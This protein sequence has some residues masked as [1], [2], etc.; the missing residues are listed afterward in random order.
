[1]KLRSA[2]GGLSAVVVAV[3][4]VLVGGGGAGAAPTST[5]FEFVGWGGGSLVRAADNTITSDL[6][7]ASSINNQGLVSDT[8]DV[9]HVTVKDL[10]NTGEV[11]T[12]A[13]SSA[14]TGGYQV[15]SEARTAGI[16][17]LGGLITADAIDT[18]SI[19]RVVDGVASTSVSTTFVNLKVGS[20]HV[21]VNVKPNTIIRIPNVATVALNYQ[22][23]FTQNTDSA[24]VIGIGAYVSLLKPRGENAIGAELAISPT[25]SQLEPVVVP[26]SGHFLYAKAYGTKVTAKVGDLAGIQSDETAPITMAAAGTPNGEVDTSEIAGV[27]LNPLATVG[28]VVDSVQGTNTSAAY[29]GQ[30][31]SRIGAI[32]LLNGLIRADAV[33]SFARVQG[34]ATP[35]LPHVT[36]GST[37]VNLIING[38]PITLGT[39][40]NKVINILNVAKIT[41]NQQIRPNSHSLI[42]RALDIQLLNARSGFPAGAEIEVAVTHVSVA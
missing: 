28:A 25:T 42:V 9:A 33:N 4:A 12:S 21:P 15:R 7:A 10:L 38:K 3:T 22:L 13:A 26:P 39:G 11:A 35:F 17:A 5:G 41:I 34:A 37:L 29:D 16:S 36:G 27:H 14:I 31:A 30:A 18:T 23:A 19:A 6:T 24:Y 32:N 40:V 8:N 20:I 2:L 1:M